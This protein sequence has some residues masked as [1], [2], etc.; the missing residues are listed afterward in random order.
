MAV[1][2]RQ[3][4]ALAAK[5]LVDLSSPS[6]FPLLA[7]SL[8]RNRVLVL[9]VFADSLLPSSVS[10]FSSS[11]SLSPAFSLPPLTSSCTQTGGKKVDYAKLDN[12]S[13]HESD[14]EDGDVDPS[15]LPAEGEEPAEEEDEDEE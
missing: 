10:A 11:S 9:W 8:P 4:L 5:L 2:T 6:T 12:G 13:D 7:L 15:K 14:D 3:R 1:E